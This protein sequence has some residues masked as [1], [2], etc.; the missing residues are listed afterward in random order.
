MA[1]THRA[2]CAVEWSAPPNPSVPNT[3]G[4]LA[5]LTTAALPVASRCLERPHAQALD[6]PGRAERQALL[7]VFRI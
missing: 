6:P 1:E 4:L 2:H 7:Q 3:P 5:W